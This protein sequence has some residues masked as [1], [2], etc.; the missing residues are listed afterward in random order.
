MIYPM[1]LLVVCEWFVESRGI[2]LPF[3]FL[4]RR[5]IFAL[6]I[7]IWDPSREDL[8]ETRMVKTIVDIK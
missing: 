3:N 4:G 1:G 6:P 8:P 2:P 7:L 5:S